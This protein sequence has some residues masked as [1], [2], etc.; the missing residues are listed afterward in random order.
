MWRSFLSIHLRRFLVLETHGK[1]KPAL[2]K[3]TDGLFHVYH[4]LL[5]ILHRQ[6]ASK[7][8]KLKNAISSIA[9]YII[10]YPFLS[11]VLLNIRGDR[12]K[13]GAI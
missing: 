2:L 10:E 11:L 1:L 7:L 8:N 4:T 9:Y 5:I 13:L 3:S 12:M 6:P